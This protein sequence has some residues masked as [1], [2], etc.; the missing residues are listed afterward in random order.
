[1]IFIM[2]SHSSARLEG[3]SPAPPSRTIRKAVRSGLRLAEVRLRIPV[4]LLISALVV[5]RWD[6]IRNYWDKLTHVVLRQSSA[7]SPVSNDTE[8]Q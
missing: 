1:L 7:A 6:V 4:V 5:G 3:R 2:H 8:F